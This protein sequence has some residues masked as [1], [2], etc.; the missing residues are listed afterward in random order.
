MTHFIKNSIVLVVLLFLSTTMF[1][2]N[3]KKEVEEQTTKMDLFSSKAGVLSKF[4]D[5]KSI[6]IPT[7]YDGPIETN[8]RQINFGAYKSYFYQITKKGKYSYRTASIE[9]SD[10]LEVIKAFNELSNQLEKDIALKPYYLENEFRTNDWF[11]LG[12]YISEGKATWYIKL[13]RF[14]TDDTIIID[15]ASTINLTLDFAKKQIEDI[16]NN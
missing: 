6:L 13:T 4:I 2:Q 11:Q 3:S 16:M 15:K 8:I 14:G 12:Y 5:T 1:S 7:I 9:Y 10:L